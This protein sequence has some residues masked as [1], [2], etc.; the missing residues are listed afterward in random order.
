MMKNNQFVQN[1][2]SFTFSKDGYLVDGQHRLAA[3]VEA[4]FTLHN[5]IVIYDVDFESAFQSKDSGRRRTLSDR[6]S[7]MNPDLKY[8]PLSSSVSRLIF[9]S[10]RLN[11]LNRLFRHEKT[12]AINNSEPL[13]VSFFNQN[14]IIN[15]SIP[16]ALSYKWLTK[17]CFSKSFMVFA[18]I[19]MKSY[20]PEKVDSFLSS[21]ESGQDLKGNLFQLRETLIRYSLLKHKTVNYEAIF[22]LLL[23]S[24][25]VYCETGYRIRFNQ[26]FCCVVYDRH[27]SKKISFDEISKIY[28]DKARE[29]FK[30]DD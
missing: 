10:F 4:Q 3:C 26:N 12:V 21:L 19:L 14:L 15:Q 5:A 17:H 20:R 22:E 7:V 6:I 11:R 16:I 9:Y 8:I 2:D 13:I 24:Y 25:F 23:K 28:L 29:Q 30:F 1:G 27:S 18:F